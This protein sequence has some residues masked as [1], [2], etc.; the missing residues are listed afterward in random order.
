[1]KTILKLLSALALL[2]LP[3]VP[4]L[5]LTGI[6]SAE[7]SKSGLL[8]GTVLWFITAPFW[9]NKKTGNE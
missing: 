1:M 6:G 8:V 9:M 2:I 3:V 7:L 4:L 5:Q